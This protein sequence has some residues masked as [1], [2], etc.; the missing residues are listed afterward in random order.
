MQANAPSVELV[1]LTN[2]PVCLLCLHSEE[3]QRF[4]F[5][6]CLVVLNKVANDRQIS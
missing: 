3:H 6:M 4:L 5:T 1:K 2:T